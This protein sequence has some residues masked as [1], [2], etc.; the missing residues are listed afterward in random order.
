MNGFKVMPDVPCPTESLSRHQMQVEDLGPVLSYITGQVYEVA[1]LEQPDSAYVLD[2]YENLA[3][4]ATILQGRLSKTADNIISK[5]RGDD[6]LHAVD[7][8]IKH[9]QQAEPGNEETIFNLTHYPSL[10]TVICEGL[11]SGVVMPLAT[12]KQLQR[13]R[14][15]RMVPGFELPDVPELINLLRDKKFQTV[16]LQLANVPNGFYGSDSNRAYRL[17]YSE[18]SPFKGFSYSKVFDEDEIKLANYTKDELKQK[19][20]EMKSP[21]LRY[22]SSGCPVRFAT[23]Q[24]LGRYAERFAE[25]ND[26]L[27]DELLSHGKPVIVSG[28]EFLA[29]ELEKQLEFN[30]QATTLG[31]GRVGVQHASQ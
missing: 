29:D 9:Q 5:Q 14:S 23:F 19:Q 2:S 12:Y 20:I 8:L 16:L 22:T 3:F 30:K 15:N 17:R 31:V 28:C 11:E 1:G 13:E 21:D 26:L 25:D 6:K 24:S 4:F 7:D 27:A 10:E 18:Y